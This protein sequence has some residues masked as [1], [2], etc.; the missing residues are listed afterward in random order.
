MLAVLGWL[1]CTYNSKQRMK[2]IIRA[3]II[4][5]LCTCVEVECDAAGAGLALL[6]IEKI[7]TKRKAIMHTAG[8]PAL[9]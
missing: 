5:C 7:C 6:H 8:A 1:C 9:R 3:I 4:H 2:A